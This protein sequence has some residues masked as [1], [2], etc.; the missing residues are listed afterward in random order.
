MAQALE[1]M[2]VG[3]AHISSLSAEAR[4]KSIESESAAREGSLQIGSMVAEVEKI[5]VAISSAS[6][7]AQVLDASF[8][9][10]S[11]ITATI[12]EVADQT[13][14]LALNAAIEA[15]RAG[16]QGRGFAVVADEVRKL[17]EK[18]GRSAEEIAATIGDVQQGART[19]AEQM[20]NSV[21]S[22]EAG[23][24]VTQSAGEAVS[25]ITASSRAAVGMIEDLN[26][27]LTEQS[28]AGATLRQR[29]QH[30]VK[31]VDTAVVAQTADELDH[32]A[33]RLRTNISRYRVSD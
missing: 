31:M 16:E 33:D 12:K 21:S 4:A 19:L 17:A 6:T 26:I 2:A 10:I 9:R 25:A 28:A 8:D 3:I 32:L 18:T 11:G 1:G 20:R 24:A 5:S 7:S 22:V 13:N 23:M 30:I 15:A 14:L 29:V 27:A